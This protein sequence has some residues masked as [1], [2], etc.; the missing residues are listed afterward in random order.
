MILRRKD[1]KTVFFI[2]ILFLFFIVMVLAVNERNIA[3]K[4]NELAKKY[5]SECIILSN[6]K[7]TFYGNLNEKKDIKY[8]DPFVI[9]NSS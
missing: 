3:L 7:S 8:L 6:G 5:N 1:E 9:D 4:Y 2:I